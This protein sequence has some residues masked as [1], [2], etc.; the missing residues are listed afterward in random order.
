MF[1]KVLLS[2][3]IC[4]MASF[5]D[6]TWRNVSLLLLVFLADV[7]VY[8]YV[9]VVVVVVVVVGVVLLLLLI[10]I[11][12]NTNTSLIRLVH[13]VIFTIKRTRHF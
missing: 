9:Y 2:L 7:N 13:Q 10:I 3:G 8:V 6:M 5:L 12:T 1:E 11:I 4:I